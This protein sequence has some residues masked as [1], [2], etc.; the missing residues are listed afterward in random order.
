M[1]QSAEPYASLV[2]SI[3]Q[4]E[5]TAQ[6]ITQEEND[7][8][9]KHHPLLN[10]LILS[11][12][13]LLT[14]I[15][16]SVLDSIDLMIIS[17]RFKND[18]NSYA[19]Q[20]IGLG[21]FIQQIC[22]DIGMFLQQSI[23]VRV[24]S[25]IG[26][27]RRDE[28]CQ[29][30]VDIYRISI[31]INIFSTIIITLIARPIMIFAGCTP[32]LIEQ[33]MLL[34]ISLIAGLP[35]STLFHIG[36]GFLQAIGKAVMNGILH[37]IANCLQTFAITPF[38]QYVVKIDVTLSNISQPIAQSIVGMFV[39]IMIF[40][41][42][43]SLK[44]NYK[45]L[46][47]PFTKE[48]GK[49]LLMSLPIIPTFIFGIL[50]SSLILRYMTSASASD[51]LKTDVIGVYTVLQKI[52]LI[53]MALPMALSIGCLTAATHSMAQKNYKR[54]LITL[55]WAL[56]IIFIF[57]AI[58]VP[59]MI[60]RPIIFMKLFGISSQSQ[61]E[62]AKKMV[63]IP[64]YTFAIGNMCMFFVNFFVAVGKPF[65]S[66][67]NSLV[68][69]ISICV[70]SKLLSLKFPNDPTKIMFSYTISDL[71]TVVLTTTLLTI[72]LIPL[73]KK[74]KNPEEKLLSPKSNFVH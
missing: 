14:T 42:K 5:L 55:G 8:F 65:Y 3:S 43:Y 54:M 74:S 23:M 45:M 10:L 47:N 33:C 41:G 57:F 21:F 16:M 6:S 56:L 53:G 71:I 24:S 70:S 72:T 73:V 12:G 38:L 60:V 40:K 51:E 26:E 31:L 36:T 48:T 11:I 32:D 44:P 22:M 35:F 28:A 67:L 29:L 46:F 4:D 59:L 15:G 27:G 61:L 34:V 62:I 17:N 18:P 9:S 69:L 39:L 68:Q 37:L 58:F 52:F 30:T 64:L 66:T 13:P 50:P 49:S 2:S 63:P 19:V 20:I 7:R 1:T 25:L